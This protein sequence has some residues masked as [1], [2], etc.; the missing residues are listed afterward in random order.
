MRHAIV[1]LDCLFQGLELEQIE[2]RR[3]GLL[4]GDRH[5]AAGFHQ[6]RFGIKPGSIDLVTAV[7]NPASLVGDRLQ[8]IHHAIHRR[9]VH[10]RTHE[11]GRVGR[12]VD[13]DRTIGGY[14][15][16]LHLGGD[17]LLEQ[18]SSGR[19]APLTRGSHGGKQNGPQRQVEIGI[20]HHNDVMPLLPPSSSRLRPSR[21]ATTSPIRRPI[22]TEPVAEMRGTRRSA[23]SGPPT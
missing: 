19:R 7:N 13:T 6:R 17:P 5:V 16:F 14:E 9:A 18:E 12:V 3:E 22:A 8:S 21:L 10:Q 1:E 20:V 15:A 11:C 4:A 2:N 23:T